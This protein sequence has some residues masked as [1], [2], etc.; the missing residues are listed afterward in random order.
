MLDTH[1]YYYDFHLDTLSVARGKGN[2][3]YS[4]LYPTDLNGV[5]RKGSPD[6][7]CYQFK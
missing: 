4:S 6:V 2:A 3:A 7:G 1:A 5:E